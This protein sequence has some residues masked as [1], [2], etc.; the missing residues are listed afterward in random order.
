MEEEIRDFL[1][2]GLDAS[3]SIFETGLFQ[4]LSLNQNKA[5]VLQS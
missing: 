1:E 2:S 4:S 3:D 5:G